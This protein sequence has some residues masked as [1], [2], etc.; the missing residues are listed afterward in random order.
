[1]TRSKSRYLVVGNQTKMNRKLGQ[2]LSWVIKSPEVYHE[3]RAF[4]GET[5]VMATCNWGGWEWI[6]R[7]WRGPDGEQ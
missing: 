4:K 3:H 2:F 5:E 6:V 1:M 7:G